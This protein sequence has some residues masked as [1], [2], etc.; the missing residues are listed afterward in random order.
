MRARFLTLSALALLMFVHPPV[1][2]GP[3]SDVPLT[4]ELHDFYIAE[5]LTTFMSSEQVADCA[6][7]NLASAKFYRNLEAE[8]KFPVETI[9]KAELRDQ[10][11]WVTTYGLSSGK[12]IPYEEIISLSHYLEEY[13]VQ[14]MK[15][16]AP[17]PEFSRAV[18]RCAEQK[19]KAAFAVNKKNKAWGLVDER[20]AN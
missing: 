20:D 14:E 18:K 12:T 13:R 9:R 5:M 17:S 8:G 2:A 16:D 7:L 3:T 1:S 6:A 15:G 4:P 19:R 11:F 10:D